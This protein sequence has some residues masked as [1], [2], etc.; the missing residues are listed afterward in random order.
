MKVVPFLLVCVY[1][2]KTITVYALSRADAKISKMLY[3]KS[4][5]GFDF[6]GKEK[7]FM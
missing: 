6:P 1:K 5:Y 7:K 4:I 2:I 3:N